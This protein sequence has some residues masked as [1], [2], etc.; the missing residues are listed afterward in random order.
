M[1]VKRLATV[2]VAALAVTA[3]A[4]C[5]DDDDDDSPGTELPSDTGGSDTGVGTTLPLTTTS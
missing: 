1:R 4:A 5:S 2:A 3:F